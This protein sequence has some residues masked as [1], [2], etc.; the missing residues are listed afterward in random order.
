M[1]AI[2]HS[3]PMP[4]PI[5]HLPSLNGGCTSPSWGTLAIQGGP[6]S[7]ALSRVNSRASTGGSFPFPQ[8]SA[9]PSRSNSKDLTDAEVRRATKAMVSHTC[10][11]HSNV[12]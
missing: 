5:A 4:I 1:A 8:L 12:H 11:T 10:V 2:L 7:P 9:T 6:H 3:P